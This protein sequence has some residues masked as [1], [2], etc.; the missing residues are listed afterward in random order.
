M[1]IETVEKPMKWGELDVNLFGIE[2]DWH[3]EKFEKPLAF[4]LAVDKDYLWF[5]ASHQEAALIHPMARPGVFMPELWKYDVAEFFLLNPKTGKYLE[6][7]LAPNGAWWSALFTGPRVRDSEHDK[8]I[9]EVATYA[10]MS[11]DGSWLAAAAIPLYY[12]RDEL[13]FS[14]DSMMNVN[15]IVHSPE[16]RYAS[17]TDLGGG[18][19]DYHQ[20]DKFKKVNFFKLGS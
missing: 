7:N 2:N 9:P 4:S 1:N 13:G 5:V 19:P 6:F 3:G 15:F 10:D 14:D 16:Q 8:I 17:A 12:L 11:P 20:P 18:K